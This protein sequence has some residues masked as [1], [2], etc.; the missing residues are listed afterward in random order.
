MALKIKSDRF[1]FYE[2][3]YGK[4]LLID[5]I[6]L[7]ALE[8][9]ISSAN[10]HYLSYFD[11]TLIT[12]GR[13]QF[14]L[15]GT[16][17]EL[18]QGL[19]VFSSPNQIRKWNFN[20]LPRGY[21]LIFEEAFLTS[22]LS[23]PKF[24]GKLKYFNPNLEDYSLQLGKVDTAYIINLCCEIESEIKNFRNN[25]ESIL[26]ALLFQVLIWLNRKFKASE[27]A[28]SHLE[29]NRHIH[30]F[31]RL[32][33]AKFKQEHCVSFYSDAL[34]IS[35]GHLNDLSKS[36]LGTSAKK[37]ISKRMVIEARRLLLFTDSPI[38]DIA[39]ELGFIDISYFIRWFKGE[40]GQ[41]PLSFRKEQNP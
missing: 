33:S 10:S 19:V 21:V 15:D 38:S 16:K 9:Y 26:R 37:Y 36:F 18:E 39:L 14:V 29:T 24:I 12:G 31:V 1:D 20:E 41:T 3:K 11:I 34:S 27:S 25:D 2:T 4:S 40:V 23:D 6:H 7:E 17:Y 5:L 22:F 32:V 8:N 30:R 13:G 35:A 28:Q